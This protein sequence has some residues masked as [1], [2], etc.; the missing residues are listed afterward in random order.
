MV[1]GLTQPS[2][3][4]PSFLPAVTSRVKLHSQ[5]TTGVRVL[6]HHPRVSGRFS[7]RL[8]R[9][10]V[11]PP[12]KIIGVFDLLLLLRFVHPI[13]FIT[14]T[15]RATVIAV[16]ICPPCGDGLCRGRGGLAAAGVRHRRVLSHE[17]G[18]GRS[19]GYFLVHHRL[20]STRVDD[21]YRWRRK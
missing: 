2:F 19:D 11:F 17:S 16:D 7:H 10:R 18:N 3:V 1:F 12:T 14:T 9:R 6:L 15:A 4:H 20:A 21:D 5:Y 8:Y 13:F